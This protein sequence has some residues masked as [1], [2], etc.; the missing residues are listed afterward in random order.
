MGRRDGFQIYCVLLPTTVGMDS[1]QAELVNQ[2]CVEGS[3]SY[4]LDWNTLYEEW[5]LKSSK[6]DAHLLYKQ[7]KYKLLD[8]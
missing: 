4:P 5:I 2:T 8:V 7:R 1:V 3:I 6:A